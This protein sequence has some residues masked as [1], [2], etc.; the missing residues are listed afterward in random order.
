MA[1]VPA[2]IADFLK[3]RRIVVAGVSQN[4]QSTANAIYRKLKA[5]GYD[6]IPVNPKG[7]Q[8]EGVACYRDL[9]SV[10]GGI[11]GVFAMT[12]PAVGAELV[13]QCADRGVGRIWFHRAFGQGSLSDEAV[14]ECEARGITCI[15]GA[16]P[17]MY[18]APVDPFH[19]C[20]RWWMKVTHKLPA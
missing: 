14:R 11:D 9:A 3:G 1:A 20:F 17:M 16:C 4:P 8:V 2:S 7:G 10:P 12:S 13:R 15:A 19:T 18:V 6:V 5:S